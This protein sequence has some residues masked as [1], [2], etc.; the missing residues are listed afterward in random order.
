MAPGQDGFMSKMAVEVA[1]KYQQRSYCLKMDHTRKARIVGYFFC[2]ITVTV[3]I[4]TSIVVYKKTM[5]LSPVTQNSLE[6]LDIDDDYCGSFDV[7]RYNETMLMN[8]FENWP[9]ISVYEFLIVKQDVLRAVDAH[10]DGWWYIDDD[11]L[12]SVDDTG[13]IWMYFTVPEGHIVTYPYNRVQSR[14]GKLW[15][16]ASLLRSQYLTICDKFDALII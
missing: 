12:L 14:D 1:N 5:N 4:S 9:N 13:E 2:V 6:F 3:S 7:Q 8:S 15:A 16:G 11:K 10:Q